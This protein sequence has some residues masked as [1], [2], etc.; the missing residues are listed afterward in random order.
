MKSTF[1]GMLALSLGITMM[2]SLGCK[3]EEQTAG[4]MPPPTVTVAKP[5]VRPIVEWDAYT[6]RLEATDFVE[7]RARVGG[8]LESIHF[9]EGQIVNKG[10][11]LFVIDPRPFKAEL[12]R[13][14][15]ALQESESQ[16]QQAKARLKEAQALKRQSDAQLSL[17]SA[18]VDR[19]RSLK[20]QNAVSQE[21]VDQ[22]EA[23]FLQAEADVQG[24]EAG[25]SSAEAAIATATA[26]MESA[27]AGLETARLNLGYTQIHAPVTGRIS[28]ELVTEGNLVSGGTS[29]STLLT[30]ITSVDPIH[31]TFDVHEQDVL[32]YVRLAQQGRRES[33]RVAKNPAYLSLIDE[34]GFPHR[35]HMDFVDNR[36]D[37]DTATLRARSIFRNES[38]TLVPGMF[39]RVRIPGS[40]SYKAIL[41]PDSAIGTDQ[42]SQFV[43]VVQDGIIDKRYIKTGPIADGLRV[44]REGLQ[45]DEVLVLEGLLLVRDDT[46]VNVEEGAIQVVEDGLPDKSD[47][48][49]PDQWISPEPTPL[50]QDAQTGEGLAMYGSVSK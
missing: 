21:E 29:T 43:Y 10:D 41:I 23:E 37:T 36:F 32:K 46:K 12:S 15:A 48:L 30:T 11:L 19:A 16:L 14:R 27:K 50:P 28:S 7:I 3:P 20:R 26:S 13:A 40:A 39:A 22:R 38:G 34:K 4:E 35:G 18:R 8:Y 33:S 25:I 42:S 24:S 6:G 45:G 31:C 17:A 47:P 9:D 5:V 44:V 1:A 49:T 2:A